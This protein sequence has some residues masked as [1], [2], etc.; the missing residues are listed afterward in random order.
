M[1][2]A[3]FLSALVLGLLVSLNSQAQTEEGSWYLGGNSNL[4]FASTSYEG[5]GSESAFNIG[6]KAG[7]FVTDDIMLGA[8]INFIDLDG[9]NMTIIGL[10]G[11]YYIEKFFLGGGFYSTKLSGWDSSLNS[12]GFEAGYA[13][14]L[15]DFVSIEP[16]VVYELGIGDYD[17]VNTFGVRIGFGIYL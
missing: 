17:G 6:I 3:L 12:I 4:S 11:R 5:Y 16:S 14:F 10:F 9:D 7:N 13:I 2:K 15:N 1:K 8:S